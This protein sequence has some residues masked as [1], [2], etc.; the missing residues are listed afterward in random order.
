MFIP[1]NSANEFK[2]NIAPIHHHPSIIINRTSLP[3]SS[4]SINHQH[5]NIATV[6]ALL[7]KFQFLPY[8]LNLDLFWDV[9]SRNHVAFC[10]IM[11]FLWNSV[12][13]F[14]Y[15]IFP[16]SSSSTIFTRSHEFYLFLQLPKSR[17]WHA[18]N[19]FFYFGHIYG[20]KIRNL[21][22]WIF[23]GSTWTRLRAKKSGFIYGSGN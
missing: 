18:W 22:T 6:A 11:W 8:V 14:V 4:S 23:L 5:H 21:E 16:S 13:F 12:A 20:F 9:G 19:Y 2:I 3:G 7:C 10:G 15:L 1:Q 17:N